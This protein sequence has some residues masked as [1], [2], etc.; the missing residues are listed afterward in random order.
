MTKATFLWLPGTGE[1][2]KDDLRTDILEVGPVENMGYAI[3]TEFVGKDID[4]L[5]VGYDSTIGIA[6]G[7]LNGQDHYTSRQIGRENLLQKA[8]ATEG[9][10]IFGGYSQGAGIAW[11]VMQEIYAGKH[12]DLWPRMLCSVL[13]ANPFRNK[14]NSSN[15]TTFTLDASAG[16][17]VGWGVANPLGTGISARI[18]EFNLVN[19]KDMI[20]NAAPDSFLRDVADLIEYMEFNEDTLNWGLKTY[21]NVANVNWV[22]AAAGWLDIPNQIRRVQ[23]TLREIAGYVS[24]KSNKHTSY[25]NRKGNFPVTQMDGTTGSLCQ[26]LARYLVSLKPYLITQAEQRGPVPPIVAFEDFRVDGAGWT[27]FSGGNLAKA[28]VNTGR[29]G[30]SSSGVNEVINIQGIHKA[31]APSDDY[32]IDVLLADVLQGQLDTGANGSAAYFRIRNT[33]TWGVGTAVEFRVRASG[34]LAISSVSGGTVTQKKTGS[35]SYS[36]GQTL[37]FQA[38]GNVYSII[39]L[40]TETVLLT[41]TDADGIVNTGASNRR[42]TAGQT[43]N[44]PVFQPQ[45]SCYAFDSFTI[46]DLSI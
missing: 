9:W 4:S 36:L 7:P 12:P 42:S 3:A 26:Y 21:E 22:A 2:Y 44:H 15:V 28:R 17:T 29:A 27:G 34:G 11:E 39:N 33:D 46:T 43:S 6:G 16:D 14:D 8:R 24:K 13:V 30:Q 18:P 19:P 41:W 23:T 20:T 10:L 1:S 25:D 35:G 31:T 38:K 37:R 45:W 40:T 32:A 5:W